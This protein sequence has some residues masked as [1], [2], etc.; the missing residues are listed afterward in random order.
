ML[1]FQAALAKIPSLIDAIYYRNLKR[2]P[3]DPMKSPLAHFLE[4]KN[5]HFTK[6]FCGELPEGFHEN[7]RICHV[8]FEK[9]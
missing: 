3:D 9:K 1:T 6:M 2:A 5:Y 7:E 4:S 8:F